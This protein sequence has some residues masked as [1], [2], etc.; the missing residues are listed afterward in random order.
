M[1][2]RKADHRPADH[3]PDGGGV[4][5]LRLLFAGGCHVGGFP[6]GE[7]SGFV[8]TA[9]ARLEQGRVEGSL[10]VRTLLHVSLASTE[11]IVKA[12]RD[13]RPQVLVLQVSHYESSLPLAK[14]LSRLLRRRAPEG[15]PRD[16][17]SWKPDYEANPALRFCDSWHRQAKSA[18]KLGVDELLRLAGHP[19]FDGARI[20]LLLARMLSEVRAAGV[21]QVV[22]LG[23]FPARD[24]TIA[25]YRRQLRQMLSLEAA[26]HG[27]HFLDVAGIDRQQPADKFFS[28]DRHLSR[29]GHRAVG[30]LLAEK[31]ESLLA[32][33]AEVRPEA[34]AETAVPGP[35]RDDRIPVGVPALQT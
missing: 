15:P 8:R 5:E 20:E 26:R 24:L 10:E 22:V 12:C 4:D 25:R 33:S 13:W 18:L 23:P 9:A 11:R 6:V 28:D 35:L 30:L 34:A 27:C 16:V 7:E 32:A 31:I 14:R 3:G 29:A 17:S 19:A 2:R 1:R 21:A